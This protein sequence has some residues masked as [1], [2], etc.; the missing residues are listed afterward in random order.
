MGTRLGAPY[1][2]PML[3][4]HRTRRSDDARQDRRDEPSLLAVEAYTGHT[5]ESYYAEL[6]FRPPVR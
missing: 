5:Q 3:S 2:H 4:F 1:G 6:G